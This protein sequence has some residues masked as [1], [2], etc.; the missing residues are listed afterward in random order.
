MVGESDFNASLMSGCP[1]SDHGASYK[2]YLSPLYLLT[3][4][5][6]VAGLTSNSPQVSFDLRQGQKIPSWKRS[7]NSGLLR[8]VKDWKFQTWFKLH[9]M[10]QQHKRHKYVEA[11]QCFFPF[12]V[13]LK[14]LSASCV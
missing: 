11:L 5:M 1:P 14:N 3:F 10:L 8:A 9:V 6:A 7:S 13:P 4:V 12:C 2:M